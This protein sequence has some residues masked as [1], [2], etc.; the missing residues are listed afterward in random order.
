M[1]LTSK[2]LG[3]HY[4]HKAVNTE[5]HK[6]TRSDG[7]NNTKTYKIGAERHITVETCLTKYHTVCHMYLCNMLL[8]RRLVLFFFISYCKNH[9]SISLIM[10]F[11][12]C[13]ISGL[14]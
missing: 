6:N 11:E 1:H 4:H 3:V 9:K 14:M 10:D 8:F 7:Y 5:S 2:S 13:G 12:T